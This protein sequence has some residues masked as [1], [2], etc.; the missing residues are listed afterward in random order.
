MIYLSYCLLIFYL[1]ISIFFFLLFFLFVCLFVLLLKLLKMV[2]AV[3][4]N[5][6]RSAFNALSNIHDVAFLRKYLAAFRR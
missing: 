2:I 3:E 4:F 1:F 5:N 6:P